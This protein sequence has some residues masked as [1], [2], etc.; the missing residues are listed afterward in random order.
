MSEKEGLS[1]DTP[2]LPRALPDNLSHLAIRLATNDD[3][4][5]RSDGTSQQAEVVATT[6]PPSNDLESAI[7]TTLSPGSYTAILS[8]K[9]GGTGV[10]L[11]EVYK[12]TLAV[13]Q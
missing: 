8:G 2:A 9:N 4:K 7:V 3:W 1:K 10:G 11:V 12:V 6:I 5:I 13:N